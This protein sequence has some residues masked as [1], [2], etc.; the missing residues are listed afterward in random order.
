MLPVEQATPTGWLAAVLAGFAVLCIAST[1]YAYLDLDGDG[2]ATH[3]ELAHATTPWNSDTDGDLLPDKWER[4]FGL[5]PTRHDSDGDGLRDDAEIRGGTD[6]R[7][8]D[9]DGDG[10]GDMEDSQTAPPSCPDDARCA[11]RMPAPPGGDSSLGYA[12]MALLVAIGVGLGVG[13]WARRRGERDSLD[14]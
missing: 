4:Q 6:P 3:E 10:V 2:W 1:V 12:G 14:R 8:P 9:T 5:Q 7:L 11:L 13:A